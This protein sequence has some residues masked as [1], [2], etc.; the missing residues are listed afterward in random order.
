MKIRTISGK[1]IS[2]RDAAVIV[3]ELLLEV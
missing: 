3:L 1:A 2:E